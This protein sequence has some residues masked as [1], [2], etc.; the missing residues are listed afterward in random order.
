[1]TEC[2]LCQQQKKLIKAHIIPEAF[3]E[4][5]K[6]GN[7]PLIILGE[8]P[9]GKVKK[10][11]L[12][13]YDENILCEECDGE[14]GIL[15]QHAAEKLLHSNNR[16]RSSNNDIDFYKYNDADTQTIIKFVASVIWRASISTLPFL[17]RVK[18][19]NY[20]AQLR[21]FLNGTGSLDLNQSILI[22]EF[23]YVD[24]PIL[25]PFNSRFEGVNI[26]VLQA[27]RFQFF[28]KLDKRPLPAGIVDICLGSGQP[29]QTIVSEWKNSR[30]FSE[31]I[32]LV[33]KSNRPKLPIK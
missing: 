33:R 4:L 21:D 31:S 9:K 30:N 13:Y 26:V 20:E 8:A 6:H 2:K 3:Y 1:M 12:G 14:L 19:G 25:D 18:T 24:A 27:N 22:T 32:G 28:L 5:K 29:V 11:R 23:D 17:K 7:L 16:S 15:D 10:S